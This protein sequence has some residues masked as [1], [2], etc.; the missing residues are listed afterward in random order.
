MPMTYVS[1]HAEMY[2][3]VVGVPS[4]GQKSIETFSPLSCFMTHDESK[5]MLKTAFSSKFLVEI[6]R[7]SFGPKYLTSAKYITTVLPVW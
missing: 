1:H 5:Y 6:L 7:L 3:K 2:I 4:L